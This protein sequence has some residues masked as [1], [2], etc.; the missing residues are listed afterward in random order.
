MEVQLR[1]EAAWLL[2]LGLPP[3]RVSDVTRAKDMAILK[4]HNHVP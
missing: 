4:A 3:N 2:N 1:W